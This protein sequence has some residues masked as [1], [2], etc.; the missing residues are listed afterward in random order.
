MQ[1]DFKRIND[2]LT[3]SLVDAQEYRAHR[4]M[5]KELS[6]HLPVRIPFAKW[7]Q[8]DT[9]MDGEPVE[10][11]PDIFQRVIQYD[12]PWTLGIFQKPTIKSGQLLINEQLRNTPLWTFFGKLAQ[13]G[14]QTVVLFR[15]HHR[16]LWVI[17]NTNPPTAGLYVCVP[18]QSTGFNNIIIE[19]M[20]AWAERNFANA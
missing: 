19:P 10:K 8:I 11:L 5:L 13:T 12:F 20:E 16:G 9:E 18:A 2:G 4:E 7:R 15:H 17:H 6:K 3:Q 14:G 1:I